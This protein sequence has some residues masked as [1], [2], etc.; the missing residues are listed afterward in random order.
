MN[1]PTTDDEFET[2][3]RDLLR[4]AT[5]TARSELS[6]DD[7]HVAPAAPTNPTW[8]RAGA[9]GLTAAAAVGVLVWTDAAPSPSVG[10][11]STPPPVSM[12]SAPS[13]PSAPSMPSSASGTPATGSPTSDAPVTESSDT[14]T[15]D[16]F[17]PAG[18]DAVNILVV[19]VDARPDC[20]DPSSPFAGSY[21][22]QDIGARSDT[23]MILRID[24]QAGRAAV[25]SFPRDLW[26]SMG[27]RP[28]R[29]RIN[30]LVVDSDPSRLI[31]TLDA[32]FGLGVDHF[33]QLDYCGFR[34]LVDA[35]G[36]VGVPFT[37]PVRDTSTGFRADA[38]ACVVLD[39]ERALAYVRSRRME[40]LSPEG[41][42]L[43]DGSSDLSR[44]ARQQDLLRRL[45]DEV[46]D[47][48]VADVGN[49]RTLIA[50][51]QESLV[52]DADLTITLMLEYAGVLTSLE[53]ADIGAHTIDVSGRMIGGNSVLVPLNDTR[54]SQDVLAMFRG[55]R[56]LGE[57]TAP[58]EGDG[59]ITTAPV[60]AGFAPGPIVPDPAVDC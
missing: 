8:A 46:L 48:G 25:L 51:M 21:P 1:T 29:G 37:A 24:P 47:Q 42:W 3:L 39:G 14:S 18:E 41:S 15:G 16:T 5:A 45:L 9:V 58:P 55:E 6:F 60:P 43:I 11:A 27:G 50:A 31:A 32:D 54:H 28:G 7:V 30:G 22:A 57:V 2:E 33:V 26:V 20:I 19:G 40:M 23:T 17:P 13:A 36:G 35:V 59:A 10:S 4:R 53:P 52:V 34:D 12:P 49:V 44:V 56:P 38:P